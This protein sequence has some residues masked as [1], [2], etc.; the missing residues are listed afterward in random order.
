M[1]SVNSIASEKLARLIGTPKCPA[2]LDVR[3]DDDFSTDP[4]LVPG[5]VRRSPDTAGEWVADF[6]GRSA[7]VI[8]QKGLKLSHGVAAL[9]REAGAS[10]E[11][12]EGGF[13]AWAQSGSSLVPTGKLPPRNRQGRTLWVTRERPKIDRIACPWLIRRFVDPAALFMFIAPS[14]VEAVAKQFGAAPFDIEG[15]FWSHRGEACTFD[16][17]VERVRARLAGAAAAGDDRTRRGYRATR[18]GPGSAWPSRGVA[19][20]VAHVRRRSRTAR[21][22]ADAL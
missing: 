5:S 16:V 7:V 2:L 14:E 8:C 11:V 17:M 10:A 6:R 21:S 1:S 12:L 13:A 19:R 22:R 18:S 3:T 20:P 9:L 4:R 15:V